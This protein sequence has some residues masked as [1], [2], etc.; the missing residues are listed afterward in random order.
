M[1]KD[2]EVRDI[3]RY[4]GSCLSPCSRFLVHDCHYYALTH[5]VLHDMPSYYIK[6]LL[7]WSRARN[8]LVGPKTLHLRLLGKVF[9]A[10]QGYRVVLEIEIDC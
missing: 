5:H 2:D 6:V 7:E 9:V 4:D 8:F 1:K 3:W 10:Y